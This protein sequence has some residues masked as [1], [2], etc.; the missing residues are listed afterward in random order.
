MGQLSSPE[1]C[2]LCGGPNEGRWTC[3][4][5]TDTVSTFRQLV[6]ALEPWR[7]A[8]EACEVSDVITDDRGRE[9]SLWD[10]YR[11]Y[12]ARVRLPRQMARAIEL[13]LHDNR[14]ESD[15][16]VQMGNART[17]PVGMYATIGLTRLL[18][19]VLAGEI[20]GVHFELEV[21]PV[22]WVD[23]PPRLVV[24]VEAYEPSPAPVAVDLILEGLVA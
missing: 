16:A 18:R 21:G 2:P 24:P 20:G 6:R 7:S 9:W 3:P 15:A 13:F 11:F 17:S 1:G 14:L 5:C 12:E 19:M 23:R 10:A 8:Y 22:A 4:P